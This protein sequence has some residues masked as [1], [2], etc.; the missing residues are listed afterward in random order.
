MI[1][2]RLKSNGVLIHNFE[3]YH[4]FFLKR[5]PILKDIPPVEKWERIG[6][7]T[8]YPCVITAIQRDNERGF[9]DNEYV[10]VHIRDEVTSVLKFP[11]LP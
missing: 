11:Y 7:P 4:E 3:E 2:V 1:P 5:H 9:I 6:R 10:I 8:S